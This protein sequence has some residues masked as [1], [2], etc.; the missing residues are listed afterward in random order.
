MFTAMAPGQISISIA[1]EVP[2]NVWIE[3]ERSAIYVGAY[4]ANF[5]TK[6]RLSSGPAESGTIV[7]AESDFGLDDSSTNLFF[8]FDYRFRPRHRMDFTF[9]D[10]SRKG[11]NVI[12]RDIDFGDVTFPAGA[13]VNTGS[14]N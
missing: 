2:A 1:E 9:Y 11:S 5:D 8:H 4:F 6:I 13:T 3:Q 7:D 14:R 12:E 10:L